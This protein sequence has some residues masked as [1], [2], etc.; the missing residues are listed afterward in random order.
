MITQ[1]PYVQEPFHTEFP[2]LSDSDPSWVFQEGYRKPFYSIKTAL[3]N[4]LP[5]KE[6]LRHWLPLSV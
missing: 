2:T 4:A 5:E 1:Q 6:F 3:S